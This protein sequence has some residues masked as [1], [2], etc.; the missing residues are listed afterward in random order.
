MTRVPT[1]PARA[2][3]ETALRRSSAFDSRRRSDLRARSTARLERAPTIF[4]E[5]PDR[6]VVPASSYLILCRPAASAA[7]A[8]GTA[9]RQRSLRQ[10]HSAQT[11]PAR[12]CNASLRPSPSGRCGGL[13][14]PHHLVLGERIGRV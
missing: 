13:S 9:A 1:A 4:H 2:P 5:A 3:A 8:H 11:P 12:D 10:P 6:P 7:P 14:E